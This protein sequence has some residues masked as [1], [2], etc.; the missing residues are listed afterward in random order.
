LITLTYAAARGQLAQEIARMYQPIAIAGTGAILDA[1]TKIKQQG[2]AAIASGGFSAAWQNALRVETYPSK[3]VSAGAALLA[4]HKIPY[5]GVF[6][7]GAVIK[8]QPLLWIPVRGLP[9]RIGGRRMTPKLYEERIGP[10]HTVTIPGKPPML[11][12]S[13]RGQKLT[14]ANLRAGARGTG[15]VHDQI[16]FIGLSTVRDPKRFDL[17]KVFDAAAAGLGA[18]YLRFLPESY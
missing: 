7:R 15:H 4:H 17:Q 1:A 2:R 10:L 8:G 6:Q 14:I 12:A 9:K 13:L 11:A 5:A 16:M 18:A 3:G